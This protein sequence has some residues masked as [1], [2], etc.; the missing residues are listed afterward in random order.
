MLKFV[1]VVRRKSDWTHERFRDYFVRVHGPLAEK[2]RGFAAINRI[3]RRTIRSASRLRGIALSN[4][5]STIRTRWKSRGRLRK[6]RLL[7]PISKFSRTWRKRRGPS[8]TRESSLIKEQTTSFQ[9]KKR[10][11]HGRFSTAYRAEIVSVTK[12]QVPENRKVTKSS[13]K[14]RLGHPAWL[15]EALRGR[16]PSLLFC[17]RYADCT[18]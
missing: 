9:D 16:H 18:D 14:I 2:F 11:P 6:A 8:P 17:L 4:S 7:L 5:T 13:V 3:F 15:I 12:F 10:P 1:V